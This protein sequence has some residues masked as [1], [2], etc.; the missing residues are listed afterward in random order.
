MIWWVVIFAGLTFQFADHVVNQLSFRYF[1]ARTEHIICLQGTV[2]DGGL[3]VDDYE[4]A[5]I[6]W[7]A[8]NTA[9]PAVSPVCDGVPGAVAMLHPHLPHWQARVWPKGDEEG[10]GGGAF[11]SCDMSPRDVVTW[12]KSP[13]PL[14]IIQC[15]MYKWAVFT[16]SQLATWNGGP[17][18]PWRFIDLLEDAKPEWR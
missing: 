1:S 16:R 6:L 13:L 8:Y 17:L 15:D 11:T 9:V 10:Q 18:G 2:T 14:F 12:I 4:T 7:S 5:D 3:T